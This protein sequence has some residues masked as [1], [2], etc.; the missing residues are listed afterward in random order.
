[1]IRQ[2][3]WNEGEPARE[4]DGTAEFVNG[5]VRRS[6][7]SI[8]GD[9]RLGDALEVYLELVERGSPPDPDEFAARYGPL[10]G[11]L[12]A[13]LEGLSLVQGLVGSAGRGEPGKLEAGRKIAGYRIVR[14]LGRGGMG[15][16]YDAVHLGLDRPVA[17]KVLGMSAA[18]DASSRRRF[19]NEA[20]TAA[21]LH[22]THI[23]PVFDVGRLGG[24]CYYAMQRIEGCGL[25]RVVKGM[26]KGR[27]TASGSNRSSRKRVI[28]KK[29][30]DESNRSDET[31]PWA[32]GGFQ[33]ANDRPSD[34]DAA[35]SFDPPRG[36]AYFRWVAEIGRQA[37]EALGH[38]HAQGV[39]HRDV[40]P[41][42]LLVDA[43]GAVWVADFGLARRIK[44]PSLT[45]TE[46]LLG[47]PRYMSPEQADGG[48]IDHRTD[49]YSLGATLYELL[50]LKSPFDGDSAAELSRQI[51]TREPIPPRKYDDKIPR[52]LE[53]IVLK[54]L[55]KRPADR[56]SSAHELAD[57]L[58]RFSHHEPVRARRISPF[59]RVWRFARRHPGMSSVSVI[60]ATVVLSV[61]TF[62]YIRVLAER[63]RAV[64][65]QRVSLFREASSL[66]MSHEP[67]RRERGLNLL[68]EAVATGVG[69]ELE[70]KLR[71]EAIGFLS[72]R[73]IVSKGTIATG[74][75]Q[76][77]SFLHAPWGSNEPGRLVTLNDTLDEIDVW[78][79]DRKEQTARHRLFGDPTDIGQ[80]PTPLVRSAN[81]IGPS[82]RMAILDPWIG[83]VRG[84]GQGIRLV[85]VAT[86]SSVCEIKTPGHEILA[87]RS[88]FFGRRLVTVEKIAGGSARRQVAP[89]AGTRTGS[90]DNPPREGATIERASLMRT[91]DTD[92]TR[93]G[94]PPADLD[95]L[96]EFDT[97]QIR[98]W[99]PRH[100]ADSIAVLQR[101]EAD[102]VAFGR[103]PLPLVAIDPEGRRIAV[104]RLFGQEVS[105]YSARDGRV[106]QGRDDQTKGTIAT[107]TKISA[108]TIGPE[109]MLAVGGDG[110]IRLWDVDTGAS[111]TML[112][113]H[114]GYIRVL[115][116]S[117]RGTLLAASG[118]T[119]GIEAWDPSAHALVAVLPTAETVD[120]IVFS[121]DG[122]VMA[123]AGQSTTTSMW[124]VIEPIG[125]SELTDF[126]SPPTSLAFS[127]DGSSLAI[128]TW[129]G[130]LRV[131]SPNHCPMPAFPL[132]SGMTNRKGTA[133]EGA[134]LPKPIT[135]AFDPAGRLIALDPKT[136]RR[137]LPPKPFSKAKNQPPQPAHHGMHPSFHPRSEVVEERKAATWEGSRPA[138]MAR[139]ADGSTIIAVQEAELLICRFEGKDVAKRIR[140]PI[141]DTASNE[142]SEDPA[143]RAETPAGYFWW[144]AA[145]DPLGKRIYINNI[146]NGKNELLVF[147]ISGDTV[148]RV[149]WGLSIEVSSLAL[150]ADGAI[151]AVGDRRGRISLIDTKSGR[152]VHEYVPPSTDDA[153]AIVTLA[154]SP[155]GD[156]L[157]AGVDERVILWNVVK[158]TR[159]PLEG[160]SLKLLCELPGHRSSVTTLAFSPKG[161]LLAGGGVDRL[162]DVWDLDRIRGELKN[163]G[164]QW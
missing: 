57:D 43:R 149:K 65:A 162:V 25:D 31:A 14:E 29:F 59:G 98:L 17:L 130:D 4:G 78:N 164:L 140:L 144:N 13:A 55:A 85:D 107:Q 24:L 63:D 143:A 52:D 125:R 3:D 113:S 79:V 54:A 129:S 101:W 112:N 69:G 61:A 124:S 93:G 118:P 75:S 51:R 136:L 41:S 135:V 16:V 19:L 6:G 44:D 32:P 131:C 1:M 30:E 156:V 123:A 117:P 15:V 147:E 102:D 71:N 40:K 138:P 159:R 148:R 23:V 47:T 73:D 8:P 105:I 158:P 83:V 139:S 60:A 115:R 116:F 133:E 46:S 80:A 97:F 122:K 26:R 91:R 157:A 49:I 103:A 38:A 58:L 99:D 151:L 18:P 81:R 127:D 86:G 90:L 22:H 89:A 142:E 154:F 95:A 88:D 126:A 67:N 12:R 82:P 34:D 72:L 110:A 137:Y 56:Y 2:I 120:E 42:N 92:R 70:R 5:G 94:D 152:V 28:T 77:I 96:P 48:A 104:A 132:A 74:K 11:D 109:G 161:N 53:T 20:R 121:G 134:A 7:E 106:W 145:L 45:Q 50:T 141:V 33:L 155:T 62:A 128:G 35:V 21:G 84:D 87:I 68:R 108:M 37:A 64:A 111:L 163:Y 150:N 100:P 39:I 153:H 146:A 119:S 27:P 114:I 36:A 76:G 10:A 160:Y 9:D 66:R